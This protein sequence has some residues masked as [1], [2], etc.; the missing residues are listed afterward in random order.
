V[1]TWRLNRYVEDVY[2][3]RLPPGVYQIQVELLRCGSNLQ[4]YVCDQ[5]QPLNAFNPRGEKQGVRVTLP[6]S[7]EIR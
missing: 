1:S 3:M 4:V 5:P 2:Y 7:V 6:L